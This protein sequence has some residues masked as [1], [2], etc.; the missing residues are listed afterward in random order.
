MNGPE[1]VLLDIPSLD[2]SI[3]I[4][5][6]HVKS[7]VSR[8]NEVIAANAHLLTKHLAKIRLLYQLSIT[9]GKTE[10]KYCYSEFYKP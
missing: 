3:P 1:V 7:L 10:N 6:Q 2:C 4:H 9:Y 5:V 8:F